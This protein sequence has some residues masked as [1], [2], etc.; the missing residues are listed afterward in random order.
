MLNIRADAE[1]AHVVKVEEVIADIELVEVEGHDELGDVGG[2]VWARADHGYYEVWPGRPL[3]F[4]PPL[5]VRHAQLKHKTYKNTC[6]EPSF[7]GR[8]ALCAVEAIMCD[9]GVWEVMAVVRD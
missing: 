3:A 2:C 8:A 4:I 9:V 5:L 7:S 1:R 6:F